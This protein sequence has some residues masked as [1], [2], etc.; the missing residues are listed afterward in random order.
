MIID[1]ML[2]P[3]QIYYVLKDYLIDDIEDDNLK[4]KFQKIEKLKSNVQKNIKILNSKKNKKFNLK[5]KK[6]NL[7]K[8]YKDKLKITPNED[9]FL[10]DDLFFL[11]KIYE[12]EN[13]NENEKEKKSNR[14]IKLEERIKYKL[15]IKKI[16]KARKKIEMKKKNFRNPFLMSIDDYLDIK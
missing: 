6:E 12:E 7:C 8:I 11:N 1:D 9:S 16:K 13:K 2:N 14:L 15:D 5:K 3:E 4:E 10:E